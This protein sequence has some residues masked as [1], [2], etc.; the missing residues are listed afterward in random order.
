MLHHNRFGLIWRDFNQYSSG[1]EF[2]ASNK[3]KY[4]NDAINFFLTLQRFSDEVSLS[5]Q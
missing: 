4:S 3:N 1:L 2:V 5:C